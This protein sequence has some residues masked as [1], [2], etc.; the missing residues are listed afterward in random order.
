MWCHTSSVVLHPLVHDSV[1]SL[2]NRYVTIESGFPSFLHL[3]RWWNQLFRYNFTW[4]T[5]AI[6]IILSTSSLVFC[7]FLVYVLYITPYFLLNSFLHIALTF[8][9]FYFFPLQNNPS[10]NFLLLIAHTRISSIRS[11]MVGLCY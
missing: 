10:I 7:V 2:V 5:L 1:F 4:A 3:S 6:I 9:I 11:Q 8:F